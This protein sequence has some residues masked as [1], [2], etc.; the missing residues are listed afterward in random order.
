METTSR[1]LNQRQPVPTARI[2]GLVITEAKDEVLVYDQDKHHI[3][4]LNPTAAAVWRMCDGQR[5]ADDIALDADFEEDAVL[6]A[7]RKL[8]DAEL[9]D[10][11]LPASLRGSQSRRSFMTKAGI[12]AIP[13][14]ISVSAPFAASAQSPMMMPDD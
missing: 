1:E 14:I 5:S 11:A 13:T 3:H 7:L 10:G 2:T 8:Q 6:L 12:A 4:H 9:L